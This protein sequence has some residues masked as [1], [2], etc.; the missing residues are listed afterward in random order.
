ML[1]SFRSLILD[2]DSDSRGKFREVL[3]SIVI[4][5]NCVVA[6]NLKDALTRIESGS[7]YDAIFIS[8]QF[9]KD[10]INEFLERI[11]GH[12]KTEKALRILNLK[13]THQDSAFVAKTFMGGVDGFICEPY[14][15]DGLLTLI[16]SLK[17]SKVAGTDQT[18]RK[19]AGITFLVDDAIKQVDSMAVSLGRDPE[20]GGAGAGIRELRRISSELQSIA[21]TSKEDFE[22]ILVDKFSSVEVSKSAP[23]SNKGK[24]K[25]DV[26]VAPGQALSQ[27]LT[28]RGIHK[29]KIAEMLKIT[30]PEF[31]LLLAGNF[32]ITEELAHRISHTVGNTP[33]HWIGIQRRFDAYKL[34]QEKKLQAKH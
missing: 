32:S 15:A 31:E 22:R 7:S 12:K 5:G 34:A 11:R 16:R 26:V 8:S 19:S 6:R 4:K 27:L 17:E 13:G 18:K 24:T 28:Q 2:S 14:S 25:E 33:E 23:K 3:Q 1:D 30:E 21:A 9:G 29:E 10:K 20:K